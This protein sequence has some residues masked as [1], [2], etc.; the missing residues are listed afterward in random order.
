MRLVG[1]GGDGEGVV[2]EAGEGLLQ[3]VGDDAL[4]LD[5]QHARG[6]WPGHAH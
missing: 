3:V 6:R 1:G 5:D 2:A 4:V